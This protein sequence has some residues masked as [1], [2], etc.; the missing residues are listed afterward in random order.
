MTE[1]GLTGT[2]RIQG[3]RGAALVEGAIVALPFFILVFGVLE[4]GLLL[5]THLAASNVVTTS[6]RSA[7]TFGS[8]G[9]SD[10]EILTTIN[11]SLVGI[12]RANVGDIV[13]FHGAGSDAKPND[14]CLNRSRWGGTVGA[15]G[16]FTGACN[17]YTTDDFGWDVSDFDCDPTTTPGPNDDNWCP[18]DRKDWTANTEAGYPY[19]GTDYIGVYVDIEYDYITGIFGD[20]LSIDDQMIVR[21]EPSGKN[22]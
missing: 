14:L 10:Y 15:Q 6:S 9:S 7:A 22:R 8:D 11:E 1:L 16:P 13:I 18:Q 21:I 20:S 4:M 19:S 12:D 2:M 17:V 5:K 3:D